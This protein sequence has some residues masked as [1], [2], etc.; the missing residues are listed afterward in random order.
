MQALTLRDNSIN[1]NSEQT[2]LLYIYVENPYKA[3]TKEKPTHPILKQILETLNNLLTTGKLKLK[4]DKKRKA[5]KAI[6]KIQNNSLI[7]IQK[8]AIETINQ[9][10]Q[11]LASDTLSEI[12]TKKTQLQEKNRKIQAKKTR[13]DSHA[14]VKENKYNQI[15]NKIQKIKKL[16]EKNI[17]E[18]IDKTI[19]IE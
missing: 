6:K 12:S 14:K 8:Q 18:S 13:I 5:Q 4:S 15:N 3:L 2:S 11:L 19:K 17:Y 7:T 10:Q 16:I 1:L 9:K